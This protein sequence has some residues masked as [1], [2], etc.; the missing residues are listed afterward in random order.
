MDGTMFKPITGADAI[1]A[2]NNADSKAMSDLLLS[3][4]PEELKH[5]KSCSTSKEVWDKLKTTYESQD[6]LRK[7]MLLKQLIQRKKD[8]DDMRTHLAD[9]LRRRWKT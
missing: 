6:P 5:I 9:F 2:W 8:G 7:T 4:V 3:I 1:A